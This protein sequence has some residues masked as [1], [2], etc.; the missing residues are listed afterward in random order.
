[1]QP[2]DAADH[3]AMASRLLLEEQMRSA[4]GTGSSRPTPATH[5]TVADPDPPPSSSQSAVLNVRSR[6]PAAPAP[7][8]RWYVGRFPS[9]NFPVRP[10]CPP[11]CLHRRSHTR[12]HHYPPPLPVRPREDHVCL[13]PPSTLTLPMFRVL[14]MIAS[15]SSILAVSWLALCAMPDSFGWL[16]RL[17]SAHPG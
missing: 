16:L 15:N 9:A 14:P 17:P 8:S 3:L 10:H 1:M 7:Q 13:S 2:T 5:L 12:G 11:Q 4:A 6:H